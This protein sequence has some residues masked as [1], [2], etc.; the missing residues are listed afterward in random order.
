MTEEIIKK[1]ASEYADKHEFSEPDLD[2]NTAWIG[3]YVEDAFMAGAEWMAKQ[4]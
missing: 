2:G 1:A 4:K 3:C